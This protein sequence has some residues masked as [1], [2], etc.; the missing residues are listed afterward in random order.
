MFKVDAVSKHF[1]GLRALDNLT[2]DVQPAEIL[3]LVGPNGSGKS[4]FLNVVTGVVAPT[5]GSIFF[6]GTAITGWSGHRIVQRGLVRTFQNIRLFGDLPVWQNLWIARRRDQGQQSS[7]LRRWLSGHGGGR[8]GAMELL[9]FCQLEGRAEDL[10]GSLSFG[11]QR[12]LELARALATNPKLLLLD[13]PA[14][15]MSPSEVAELRDRLL[16]LKRRGLSIV[17]IE[18]AMDLVMT[19]VD[20]VVVLNFGQVLAQGSPSSIQDNEAVRD[21]FLGTRHVA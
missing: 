11:E 6:E 17:L 15:G 4:T 19:T 12:R 1:G 8:T 9:R 7:F 13:E 3:G 2:F 21:A 16:E 14:A 5:S 20:R 10:A 18:H